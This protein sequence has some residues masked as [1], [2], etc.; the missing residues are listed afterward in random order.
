VLA[1]W[2]HWEPPETTDLQGI[3]RLTPSVVRRPRRDDQ[4]SLVQNQPAAPSLRGKARQSAAELVNTSSV[5]PPKNDHSASP[6]KLVSWPD[7]PADVFQ[8]P[9]FSAETLTQ[10]PLESL[11]TLP[12]DRLKA[13]GPNF[14]GKIF[15]RA[16]N[17]VDQSAI[18]PPKREIVNA[19][20]PPATTLP[21]R[22]ESVLS[23]LRDRANDF[24]PFGRS[25]DVE[26]WLLAG[27]IQSTEGAPADDR[28]RVNLV[29]AN[30]PEPLL[31]ESTDSDDDEIGINS[32]DPDLGF[33]PS[34]NPGMISWAEAMAYAHAHPE[35]RKAEALVVKPPDRLSQPSAEMSDDLKQ[36]MLLTRDALNAWMGVIRRNSP[37]V[38]SNS[39][40][41]DGLRP[42]SRF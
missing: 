33:D 4:N 19:T 37:F 21:S 27:L 11:L 8:S 1:D 5:E 16:R 23:I 15:G 35:A 25:G 20:P 2:D 24:V 14:R 42:Q 38:M 31:P 6:S 3:L 41:N 10:M 32:T 9:S 18:A 29:V 7:L 28:D 36:A 17:P 13:S 34:E 40:V 39:I 30:S 12:I 26:A 22:G